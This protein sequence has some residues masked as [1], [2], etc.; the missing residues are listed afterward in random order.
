MADRIKVNQRTLAALARPEA[1]A[2]HGRR[3]LDDSLVGFFITVGVKGG[4]TFAV[5]YR[6]AGRRRTV[7][8]G[9]FGIVKPEDARKAALAVLGDAARGEDTAETRTA[10]R[11]T[12]MTFK[13][14]REQYAKDTVAHLKRQ[15]DPLRYLRLA[16][17]EW[18]PRPL[19]AITGD[20]VQKIL[21]RLSER[22]KTQ[23]NRWLAHVGAAFAAA[24]RLG[25]V[26][27]N[28]CTQVRSFPENPARQ[29]TA[30]ADE[31]ARLR[32]ALDTWPDPWEKAAF[33][34]LID[35]GARLSE[36]LHAKHGDFELDD[37]HA[38]IWHLPNT[39]SGRPQAVP[40]L[41]HVGAV[42][43]ATP[44]LDRSEYLVPGS[45]SRPRPEFS[46]SWTRLRLAAKIGP[47]LHIHDLRRSFGLRVTRASGIFA[48]SK[49]LRHS[50]VRITQA[51]YAPLDIEDL[52]AFA[53]ATEAVR[54]GKLEP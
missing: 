27:R 42:V 28:P 35:A 6:C 30:T 40:I 34:L 19:T 18:D 8:L 16:G 45:T 2:P 53:D 5:R 43:A 41:P 10:A 26:E 21:T 1:G 32:E 9:V 22:G 31:E 46:R 7:R 33:T 11:E 13:A 50:D 24:L 3:Y 17:E 15:R 49:L 47:D 4:I 29:R 51:V 38:G 14:W 23:A 52:R 20:D 36:V 25:H 44:V 39:K 37:D 54:K 12:R 48:A